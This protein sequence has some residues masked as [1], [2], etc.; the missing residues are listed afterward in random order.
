MSPFRAEGALP[1]SSEGPPTASGRRVLSP[2]FRGIAWT[3]LSGLF[4]VCVT[5]IVRHIGSDMSAIQA[6][7]I[8]YAFGTLLLLPFF[9]RHGLPNLAR[10]HLALNGIRGV[11][12]GIGVMLW[13]F[14]MARIPIADVTAISFTAP[15]FIT[16][17]AALFL[18]ET[19]RLR[20]FAAVFIGFIGTLVIIRPGLIE[21]DIG[22][23][24]QL[25]AAPLFAVSMLITKRLTADSRPAD[26]VTYLSI[27][28]T[29]VLLPGAIYFWQTPTWLELFWLFLVAACAT[30]GHIA[31]TRAF[32]ATDITVT[33]PISFL[34]LIWAT[35]V[36][37][38][39]FAETPDFWTIVGGGIIVVSATYIAHREARQA[40][41]RQGPP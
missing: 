30:A 41:R 9:F 39:L 16:I 38:L 18:G 29:I 13:F 2:T 19:F 17:G 28:V 20:R 21:V 1:E 37:Y 34:Q 10:A 31:L 25:L 26:I 27:V 22:A 35:L 7:F 5:A 40:G 15:I 14:A 33:Q 8:R 6:A 23:L 32:Q 11:F 12:H 36:G 24:A 4:F 3:V